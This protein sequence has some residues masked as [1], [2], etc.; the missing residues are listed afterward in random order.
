M[1]VLY[2]GAMNGTRLTIYDI[3]REYHYST[4]GHRQLYWYED[5]F[6]GELRRG[7]G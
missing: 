5:L 3:F 1:A 2:Q 4:W 6:Y 7:D